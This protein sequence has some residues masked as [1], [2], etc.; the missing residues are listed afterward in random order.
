[1]E[2]NQSSGTARK[3]G[4]KLPK[5]VT[6]TFS[7]TYRIFRILFIPALCLAALVVGLTIGYSTIGGGDASDVFKFETWKH[8]YDLVFEGTS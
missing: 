3:Q 5:G 6:R 7:I 8:L 2:Q 4:K 1:M